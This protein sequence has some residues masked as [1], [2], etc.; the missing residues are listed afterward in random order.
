M[1]YRFK[2]IADSGK[3]SIISADSRKQAIEKYRNRQGCSKEYV[4]DHC[5]VKKIRLGSV[6]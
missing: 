6:K 2:I 5:V 4:K 3:I 1:I